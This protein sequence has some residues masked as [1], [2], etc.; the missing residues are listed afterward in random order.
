MNSSAKH[1]GSIFQ[2][3]SF[4]ISLIA[5]LACGV[6][7]AYFSNADDSD[8]VHAPLTT[9]SSLI[10]DLQPSPKWTPAEVV[11]IQLEALEYA[12]KDPRGFE[13]CFRFASPSNAQ[14][15]GSLQNFTEVVQQA[16]SALVGSS[17]RLMGREVVLNNQAT[18]LVNCVAEDSS[19]VCYRF[20]LSKEADG[21]YKD[22]WLTDSV[23]II[24]DSA[25][26]QPSESKER[27]QDI[28]SINQGF[29]R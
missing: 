7:V 4:V 23:I 2:R 6:C 21:K 11:T 14:A 16:Y 19:I 13:C 27:S 22:C 24:T 15:I 25:P 17:T 1:S 29:V 20:L 9:E 3:Y 10:M 28:S 8:S 5:G 18:V 12:A 26:Q